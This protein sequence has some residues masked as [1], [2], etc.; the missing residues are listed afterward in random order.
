[1]AL[2]SVRTYLE[3][4]DRAQLRRAPAPPV[5]NVR[6]DQVHDCPPSFWR[7]LYT[8]VGAKYHWHDRLP[9]TRGQIARYL[10]DPALSLYVMW[11]SG[12]P[13]GYFELRVEADGAVEIVYFGLLE[14]FTGRGLGAY[15]LSEA[16]TRAWAAGAT[17]VW[18]HTN[19]LDHPAA[20]PNYIKRGFTITR[21]EE[22]EV[23]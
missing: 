8:E 6:I 9:W 12:A 13:A 18:L 7:Y 2:T 21:T 10:A 15:M 3:M 23:T 19:T 5:P 11:V 17:L 16:V 4:R 1:M 14:Q 22:Y 20:L